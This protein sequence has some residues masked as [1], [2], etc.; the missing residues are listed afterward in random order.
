M[1][2]ETKKILPRYQRLFQEKPSLVL[3]ERDIEIIKAVYEYRF[4]N[5]ELIKALF[6]GSERGILLRL[7]KLFHHG[8]LDRLKGLVSHPIV[9]ALGDRGADLL[10]ESSGL[11]RGQIIWRKKNQEVKE[12]YLGHTLQIANFRATLTLALKDKPKTKI[13]SWLP[14]REIKDEVMIK[15][16]YYRKIR[17]P[18]IPDA[19]LTIEDKEDLLNFFLEC[20]RSTMTQERFL[21]K[22]KAYWY[23]WK[24]NQHKKKLEI[25]SFRVLTITKSQERKENLRE[26]TKQADDRKNGSEMFWFT[27]E[28][29]YNLKDPQSILKPIWQTPRDDTW[30]H[31]LE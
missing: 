18:L 30:H 5:S 25:D 28:E 13:I 31:L 15:E 10:S 4:L 14:E 26:L 8:Y 1:K 21:N 2:S 16:G 24:E 19:F 27:S 22:M 12:Y 29:N 11:D 17:A 7:Q 9:Y 3:Q 23:Y 20:D 6:K